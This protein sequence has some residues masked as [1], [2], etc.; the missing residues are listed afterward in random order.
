M[1]VLAYLNPMNYL[2]KRAKYTVFVNVKAFNK[3][4][5]LSIYGHVFVITTGKEYKKMK[6]ANRV[7]RV[8]SQFAV[9]H[10]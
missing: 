2:G 9:L 5:V 6:A 8:V 7:S 3:L 1:S 10:V 4:Y